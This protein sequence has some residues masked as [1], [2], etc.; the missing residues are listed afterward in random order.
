MVF[1]WGVGR[2]GLGDYPCL[3]RSSFFFAKKMK[4]YLLSERYLSKPNIII[5]VL[6][7]LN[8]FKTCLYYFFVYFAVI[9]IDLFFSVLF[10]SVYLFLFFLVPRIYIF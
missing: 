3:Y 7:K 1:V 6:P 10:L 2:D 5:L 4:R 9:V 8:S